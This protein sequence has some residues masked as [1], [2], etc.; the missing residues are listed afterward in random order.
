LREVSKQR[1]E[2]HRSILTNYCI[3]LFV[4]VFFKDGS[5]QIPKKTV[6]GK[7]STGNNGV[8]TVSIEM[9]N[10]IKFRVYFPTSGGIANIDYTLCDDET[11]GPSMTPSAML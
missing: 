7:S 5:K 9:E 3:R 6:Q 4:Q 1:Y 2:Q 8:T 10:V 11:N